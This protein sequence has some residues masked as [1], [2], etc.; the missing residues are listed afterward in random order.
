M[1]DFWKEE[2]EEGID[3]YIDAIRHFPENVTIVKVIAKVVDA[4]QRELLAPRDIWPKIR[5]STYQHQ[6]FH[7]KLE[8]R[9]VVMSPT[10]LLYL[11]FVTIDAISLKQKLIGYSF[12]PI[13]ISSTSKMPVLPEDGIDQ[14]DED[15]R[16]LHKGA[17]QMPIYSE[18]PKL[19][20]NQ[21]TYKNFIHL[22]RIPTSSV[23]IRID[24]ASIDFDGNFISITDPDAKI[25]ALAFEPAPK[26]SQQT[27]STTYYLSSDVE[28]EVFALRKIRQS[29]APLK[30]VLEAI[31]EVTGK[32]NL[33]NNEKL[34][35]EHFQGLLS[36]APGLSLLDLVYFSA[37]ESKIGFRYNLEALSGFGKERKLWQVLSSIVPPASPYQDAP[38][39]S[40]FA[41]F[42][43]SF[44]DWESKLD[45]V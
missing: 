8:C 6:T 18:H 5:E 25:A 29:D 1:T 34:M 9:G 15:A 44:I 28:R 3:I 43:F 38:N 45:H 13:Y 27:Y 41:S 42:P 22:E 32:S 19:N 35:V 7:C 4:N 10:A 39:K 31:A 16:V 40:M 30:E 12:F 2:E 33:I 17:Y 21:I 20:G 24:Y 26:Y 37:Y 23:L 14:Q 11:S 36:A